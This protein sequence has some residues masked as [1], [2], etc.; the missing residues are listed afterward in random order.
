MVESL[1]SSLPS[2]PGHDPQSTERCHAVE[3]MLPAAGAEDAEDVC[4]G[5]VSRVTC[6]VSPDERAGVKQDNLTTF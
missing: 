5:H 2:A 1:H 4:P 3:T 6:H